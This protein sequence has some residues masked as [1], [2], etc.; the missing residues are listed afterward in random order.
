MRRR[1]P[2]GDYNPDEQHPEHNPVNENR[3]GGSLEDLDS[4][5]YIGQDHSLSS[6]L[7]EPEGDRHRAGKN[8]DHD[9]SYS[10]NSPKRVQRA[11]RRSKERDVVEEVPVVKVD[12]RSKKS[13]W[14]KTKITGKVGLVALLAIG[15]YTLY[16]K[17]DEFANFESTH[18]IEGE[19]GTDV[20][21]EINVIDAHV[22]LAQI[23]TNFDLKLKTSLNRKWDPFNC[24]LEINHTGKPGARRKITTS[25]LM[26]MKL[27]GMRIIKG[28]DGKPTIVKVDGGMVLDDPFIDYFEDNY[29]SVDFSGGRLLGSKCFGKKPGK[30]DTPSRKT[31]S[32]TGEINKIRHL[33]DVVV[34]E[35]SR[36]AA[37]CALEDKEGKRAVTAAIKKYVELVLE[38]NNDQSHN[39]GAKTQNSEEIIVDFPNYAVEAKAIY[40]DRV[41]GFDKRVTKGAVKEYLNETK[42]HGNSELDATELKDCGSHTIEYVDTEGTHDKAQ[43]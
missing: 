4:E 25:Q 21:T 39:G 33:A 40:G 10:D 20:T 5:S 23:T 38:Q 27:T 41:Q 43:G 36:V 26:G 24:D 30:D 19:V 42:E 6:E 35:A 14:E 18:S 1:N 31:D 15:G 16:K 22:D 17:I 8:K 9:T 11:P 37:A 3:F 28:E 34:T 13:A 29:I 32:Q 7:E 2:E 12:V